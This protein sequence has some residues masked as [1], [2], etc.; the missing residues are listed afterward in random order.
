MPQLEP[1]VFDASSRD[2]VRSL[3]N[4]TLIGADE[5]IEG[6]VAQLHAHRRSVDVRIDDSRNVRIR[7]S[8]ENFRRLR[9]ETETDDRL[10]FYGRPVHRFTRD[11]DRFSEF[12]A[13]RFKVIKDAA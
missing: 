11:P 12:E 10:R 5:Q 4:Q 13:D 6:Y 1:I 8:D 7:L 9:Y 2:Y 3:S